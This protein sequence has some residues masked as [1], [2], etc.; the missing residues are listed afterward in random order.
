[1]ALI[2]K[3]VGATDRAGGAPTWN[4]VTGVQGNSTQK[5]A[6]SP[7]AGTEIWYW[8][9][10]NTGLFIGTANFVIPNT[11]ALTIFSSAHTGRAGSGMTSAFD[12]AAGSNG[13]STNPT[14]T[15]M[16]TTVNGGIIFAAVAT[17][18]QTWAPS[19]RTG[20]QLFD[21]DDGAHGGGAQYLLQ[22][23]A[24]SQAM[25]WTFGTSEDWGAV[26][27][28]FKEVTPPASVLIS[29]FRQSQRGVYGRIWSR[30]N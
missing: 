4:G 17:G 27:V 14:T 23:T 18:A 19:G 26:G 24:G 30:V 29:Q 1:M 25:A 9:V 21:T 13:T 28:A 22:A 6:S 15:A 16:V 3:T 5:A 2:L 12:V 7:E 8:T 11:G 10:S 20:T